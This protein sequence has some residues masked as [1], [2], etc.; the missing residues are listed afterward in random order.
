MALDVCFSFFDGSP[1]KGIVT[2]WLYP[3]Y[4]VTYGLGSLL[5][6]FGIRLC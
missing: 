5:G 6:L 3:L 2:L 4:H 1:D